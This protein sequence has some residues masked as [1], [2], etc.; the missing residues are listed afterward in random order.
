MLLSLNAS[1]AQA[2]VAEKLASLSGA[3]SIRDDL[4]AFAEAKGVPL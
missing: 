1:E 4:R 2:F 3:D